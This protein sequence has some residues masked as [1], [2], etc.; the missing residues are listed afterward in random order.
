M[1]ISTGNLLRKNISDGT[2]IGKNA[3][4]Y[5]DRGQLVP[6]K[7]MVDLVKNEIDQLV[8]VPIL[9]DGFPRTLAQAKIL[10]PSFS[11]EIV[12]LLRVPHEVII[13]RMSKRWIHFPSGRTYSYDYQPPKIKGTV[14]LNS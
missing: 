4:E 12:M 14:K 13:E 7:V 2:E 10:N 6:D 9:L 8:E 1:Q 5:M 3:K 11:V